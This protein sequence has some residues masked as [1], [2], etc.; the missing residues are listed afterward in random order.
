MEQGDLLNFLRSG[1][2]FNFGQLLRISLGICSGLQYLEG[3][4]LIHR[5]VA[6]RNVL[7]SLRDNVYVAKVIRKK[8]YLKIH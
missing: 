1:N 3:R 2:E 8:D 6:A 5:D 4:Q 7:V